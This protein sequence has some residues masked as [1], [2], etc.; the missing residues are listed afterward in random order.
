MIDQALNK[1]E[2]EEPKLLDLNQ[3]D[4][5]LKEEAA[6]LL[7]EV[8]RNDQLSF[9]KGLRLIYLGN[10]LNKEECRSTGY[11]LLE[12]LGLLNDTI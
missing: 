12:K 5:S 2:D 10:I 9:R 3:Y 6:I 11:A 4:S 7:D 8:A 1:Q